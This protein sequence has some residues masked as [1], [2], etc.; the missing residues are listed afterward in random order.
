MYSI[1]FYSNLMHGHPMCAHMIQKLNIIIWFIID[2]VGIFGQ[3]E[4]KKQNKKFKKM[5]KW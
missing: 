3:K 5:Y 1:C 2:I 4:H